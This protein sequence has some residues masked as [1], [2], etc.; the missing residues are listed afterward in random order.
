MARRAYGGGAAATT[1]AGGITSGSTSFTVTDA[2]TWPSGNPF[3]IVI[4]RGLAGEEKLL[5]TRSGNTITVSSRGYDGTTAAAHSSG[6]TVEHCGTAT[7][8][9]EANSHVNASTGV[10]GLTGAVV[11]TT[12][13]Q[14]LTNKTL[15]SPALNTPTVTGSGG[16]LT[17]PAGPDTLVGRATTDTLTNKTLTSPTINSPTFGGT[18]TN[19]LPESAITNLTTDLAAKAT[20]NAV[21]HIAGTETITGAKTFTLNPV[22]SNL[23]VITTRS[24][25]PASPANG[26][27]VYE[28]DYHALRVFDGGAS[29]WRTIYE[30]AIDSNVSISSSSTSGTT[31]LVVATAGSASVIDP[32]A[33]E[34]NFTFRSLN[35]TVAGDVFALRFY[36][37]TGGGNSLLAEWLLISSTGSTQGGT[38]SWPVTWGSTQAVDARLVRTS[39][40]GTGTFS[41]N[42]AMWASKRL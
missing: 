37:T 10:H 30:N 29:T 19:V 39:G 42:G 9:D 35:K 28:T 26:Q 40:T 2:S 21:V 36:D 12:D 17:L 8:F 14:T 3:S 27:V 25:R 16:A 5:V 15:T 7:D 24:S 41:G 33:G 18:T 32:A 4:D 34:I 31:E 38:F 11:G 20:D 22:S 13:S 1:L 6:A 23:A